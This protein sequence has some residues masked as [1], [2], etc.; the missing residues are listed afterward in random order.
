MELKYKSINELMRAIRNNNINDVKSILDDS[1]KQNKIINI[2]EE[3][4]LGNFPLMSVMESD[5]VEMFKLFINY[6]DDNDLEIKLQEN[7][8]NILC[9]NS[10]IMVLYDT[11]IEN[12]K[13]VK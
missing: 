4:E 9:I 3:D 12:R 11:F 8:I 1:I 6:I 7:D 10:E 13:E 2:S 5:N